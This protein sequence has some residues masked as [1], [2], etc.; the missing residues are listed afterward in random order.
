[1]EG[2]GEYSANRQLGVSTN[3]LELR[4]AGRDIVGKF[5]TSLRYPLPVNSC[6]CCH[7]TAKGA[8]IEDNQL[9]SPRRSEG[10]RRFVV[11]F[12]NRI[13]N[14]GRAGGHEDRRRNRRPSAGRCQPSG[15]HEMV[16]GCPIW[17]VHPLRG[18]LHHRAA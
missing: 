7:S 1:M 10:Y 16:E 14:D 18:L 11:G 8:L 6:S 4:S 17:H 2:A 12:V 3:L 13:A 15:A 9:V 5:V